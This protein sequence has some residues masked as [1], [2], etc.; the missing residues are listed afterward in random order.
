[1]LYRL[2]TLQRLNRYANEFEFIVSLQSVT[3]IWKLYAG[4][5]EETKAKMLNAVEMSNNDV[6]EYTAVL[7]ELM[8]G[9]V[10]KSN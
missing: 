9:L 6:P 3:Q 10:E 5:T 8:E 1:M 2:G 7:R 4:C